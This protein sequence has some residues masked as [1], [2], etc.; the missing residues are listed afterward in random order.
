MFF[1]KSGMLVT[2][3][4]PVIP[5]RVESSAP[6]PML[7]GFFTVW[8]ADHELYSVEASFPSF[9]FSI[10][11]VSVASTSHSTSGNTKEVSFPPVWGASP[12]QL[13][14]GFQVA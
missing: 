3:V 6:A 13:G 12:K 11:D 8:A 5:V 2:F 10:P 4:D 1:A 14:V 9:S 7:S